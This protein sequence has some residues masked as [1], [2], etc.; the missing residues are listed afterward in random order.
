[1]RLAALSLVLVLAGCSSGG[2]PDAGADELS[3]QAETLIPEAAEVVNTM[4]GACVQ[5]DGNPACARIF[6]TSDG[7]EDERAEEL[8][9]TAEAAG[10]EVAERERK[11]GGTAIEF[12][13]EGY[14]AI[15]AVWTTPCPEGEADE[16]CADEIQVIEDF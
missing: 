7:D 5:I 8:V 1:M 9:R 13:R 16:A 6:L 12:E 11:S 2:T 3:R 10:W 15:A 4:E 14:R